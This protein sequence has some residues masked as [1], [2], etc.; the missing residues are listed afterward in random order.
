[1]ALEVK[2]ED[3]KDKPAPEV[4]DRNL[5]LNRDK[6][7]IVEEGSPDAAFVLTTA[8][9]PISAEAKAEME[10]LGVDNLPD[11][12]GGK[13]AKAKKDDDDAAAEEEGDETK[14]KKPHAAHGKKH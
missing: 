11:A 13:K 2:K 9:N 12:P 8:G 14:A 7:A 3:G 1:M 10:R 4:A 5:F 6:T